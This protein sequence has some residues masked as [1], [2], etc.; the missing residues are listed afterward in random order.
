MQITSSVNETYTVNL[1]KK[2]ESWESPETKKMRDIS[3]V[4]FDKSSQ[5]VK[6]HFT[7][8]TTK[9]ITIKDDR[10]WEA[11]SHASGHKLLDLFSSYV[12][13]KIPTSSHEKPSPPQTIIEQ[14]LEIPPQDAIEK[15]E[16]TYSR[17][18]PHVSKKTLKELKTVIDFLKVE[19][20]NLPNSQDLL[21]RLSK[22]EYLHSVYDKKSGS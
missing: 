10:F 6:V 11:Q 20:S 1:P 12:Q 5:T 21:K 3:D 15:L 8:G 14:F 16:Q 18:N 7:N 17:L 4:I 19:V 9:N 13:Q 22:L 2:V